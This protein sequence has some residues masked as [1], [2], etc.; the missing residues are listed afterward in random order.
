MHS[1]PPDVLT[2]LRLLGRQQK[3][4][5]EGMEEEDE[6]LIVAEAE[7]GLRMLK[8]AWEQGYG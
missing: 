5:D 4:L 3:R 7:Q 8:S 1:H 6:D 2:Y